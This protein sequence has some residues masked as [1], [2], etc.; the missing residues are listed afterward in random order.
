MY[1]GEPRLNGPLRQVEART[2]GTYWLSAEGTCLLCLAVCSLQVLKTL[3]KAEYAELVVLFF[4]QGAALGMWFVPL[5]TVLDAHGLAG[6]KPFAFATSALAA[7]VSPL[8]FGAMADRQ[9]S[10]I[11]V[12]RGLSL[13]TAGA[14]ALAS[15]AI[16]LDWNPGLVLA[17]IQVHALCSSPTFS[18]S[19]TIIFARLAD[20]QKEFGPIR[21]MATLGW[22]AGCWV[23][24]ALGADT[25]ATAGYS[26]AVMWML[27]A[28]FTFFLP[29]L[30]TP[31]SAEHLTWHERLGLDA[32]TL[33]KNP[34]HRVVY[35][36]TAMFCI[37]LA[38]F[39][40]YAPPHLRSLGL[41]HTSAWMT[42]GQ[43]TEVIAMFTLGTLLLKWRLKW[44]FACG[45]S[46]GVLRFTLSAINAKAWMLAGVLLHG[47][48]FALVLITAQIYLDQ[49]VEASW[50]AR[51]QALLSLMNGGVGNLLGYLG[52][53]WW[54]SVCAQGSLVHWSRFWGGLAAAVGVVMA[55]FLAA[56]HGKGTGLR[57]A[58]TLGRVEI[59]PS[60]AAQYTPP[61]S[62]GGKGR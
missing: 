24:S 46:F 44:I 23:V 56:Y 53:G 28:G 40:P 38:G 22:M 15:T 32:L 6:I 16:K 45:L 25:S 26:G 51:G 21:A 11:V 3:R 9:A 61:A 33:L 30:E 54:F 19:S 8:I 59:A 29:E 36:T 2:F 42:L 18:I 4:L 41:Q 39:Y 10:P 47:C 55:Y 62:P 48:S 37:P 43:V 34:D 14:M 12:L 17:L 31:K 35:L 20:A 5:S 57:P 50:R 60:E 7:F 1:R 49:R 13:A 52:T 58:G 27:V